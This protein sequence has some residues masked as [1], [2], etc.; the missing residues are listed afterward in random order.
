M[1]TI[2]FNGFHLTSTRVAAASRFVDAAEDQ[3]GDDGAA[4]EVLFP[5]HG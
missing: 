3:N 4:D 2:R 1:N 5:T